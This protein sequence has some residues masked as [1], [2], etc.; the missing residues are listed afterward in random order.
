MTVGEESSS[1]EEI[2]REV[3][4]LLADRGT[5]GQLREDREAIAAYSSDNY[6]LLL[7]RYYRS[8][9][10]ILFSLWHPLVADLRGSP[11]LVILHRKGPE[12]RENSYWPIAGRRMRQESSTR[13]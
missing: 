12:E 6:H 3:K 1:D 11:V 5:P 10:G 4:T 9:R 8:H 2:G 13:G 7:W